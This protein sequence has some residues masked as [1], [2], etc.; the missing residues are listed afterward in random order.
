M[1]QFVY[2]YVLYAVVMIPHN[3][4]FTDKI[5]FEFVKDEANVD[6]PPD[7]KRGFVWIFLD[8]FLYG[9]GITL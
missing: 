7:P 1:M 6:K 5:T 8:I 9:I 3:G 4:F 2:L